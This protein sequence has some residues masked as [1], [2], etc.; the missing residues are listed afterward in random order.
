MA[1]PFNPN[2][3]DFHGDI[4]KSSAEAVF[5]S[6][7]SNPAISELMTVVNGIKTQKQIAILGRFNS[8]LGKGSGECDPTGRT[9]T[10]PL[11]GKLWTPAT[12]SDRLSYCWTDIEETLYI[13]ATKNGLEKSDLTATDFAL[14]VEELLASELPETA[15]R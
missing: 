6:A 8:L 15:M 9:V 13:W 12:V 3:L 1:T 4:V 7:F 10:S 11:T 5:V 2:T 14:Y